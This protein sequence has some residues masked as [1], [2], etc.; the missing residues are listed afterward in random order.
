MIIKEIS[1]NEYDEFL[2]RVESYSFLQTSEMAEVL[3]SNNRKIKLLALV[4]GEKIL[5]VGL[6]FI[7]K[8][9]GGERIDLMVGASAVLSLIHI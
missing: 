3:K 2:G 8:I 1:R 9:F 5:A 6:A 7:R 4:E